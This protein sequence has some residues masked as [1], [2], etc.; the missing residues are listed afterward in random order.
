[1]PVLA[2]CLVLIYSPQAASIY[3]IVAV[4]NQWSSK[5]W[6]ILS[7]FEKSQRKILQKKLKISGLQFP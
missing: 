6:F 4:T 1:M 2:G 7:F 5:I 3:G